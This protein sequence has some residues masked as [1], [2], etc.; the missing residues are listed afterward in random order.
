MLLRD[1]A[2]REA[3]TDAARRLVDGRGVERAADLLLAPR[4]G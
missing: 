3:H 1:D 2:R 4:G